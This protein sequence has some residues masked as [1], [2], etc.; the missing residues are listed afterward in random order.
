MEMEPFA[1]VITHNFAHVLQILVVI[2]SKSV[3]LRS[4]EVS[5]SPVLVAKILSVTLQLKRKK[6]VNAEMDLTVIRM[7]LLGARRDLKILAK[8]QIHVEKI[9]NVEAKIQKF[10]ARA[11]RVLLVTRTVKPDVIQLTIVK[12]LVD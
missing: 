1:T 11:N 3:Q 2:H 12:A 6:D 8:F 5:V 9:P 10:S 4:L 7:S